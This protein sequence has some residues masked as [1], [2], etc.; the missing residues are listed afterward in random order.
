MISKLRISVITVFA[1]FAMQSAYG[2]AEVSI[3]V[4]GGLN[5]ANV[6]TSS[7][8]AAY[9]SR[10][11]YNFGAFALFKLTKIAIQPE[12]ILSQ[13]GSTIQYNGSNFDANFSYL[14]IPVLLKLYL[15]GGLNLQVGPQFGFLMSATGPVVSSGGSIT[16]GDIKSN[17]SGS[18]ISIAM[19]AGIDL[20]FKLTV[21]AR[22]NLGVSDVNNVSSQSAI[23][24]QVFQLAVGYK[25]FKLGN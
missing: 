10:T 4:K 18:D 19:G 6:N 13:Q 14:N 20:P 2:Q 8:G 16:T 21:D 23:K 1:F 7:V 17:L 25:L 22:Y 3:G 11:G 12:L 15:I 5:F 24:N 9:N